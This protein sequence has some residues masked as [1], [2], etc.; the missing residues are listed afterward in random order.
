MNVS[1]TKERVALALIVVSMA[2]RWLILPG[3]ELPEDIS[4]IVENA[5]QGLFGTA[6]VLYLMS[7]LHREIWQKADPQTRREMEVVQRDERNQLIE[8]KA[9]AFGFEVS[10]YALA[11]AYFLLSALDCAAGAYTVLA[12]FAVQLIACLW[13][14]VRLKREM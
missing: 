11:A 4:R 2:A 10:C 3:L 6:L 13:K 12:V 8:E 1:K 7:G 5:F 14:G 9:A